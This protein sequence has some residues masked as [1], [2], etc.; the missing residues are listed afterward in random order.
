[1]AAG[2]GEAGA[3]EV[4]LHEGEEGY[5]IQHPIQSASTL[6]M[7]SKKLQLAREAA[8]RSEFE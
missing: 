8:C 7:A 1:M 6:G 2:I 4:G 5:E 3:T